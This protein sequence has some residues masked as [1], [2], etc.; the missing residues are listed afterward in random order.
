[1]DLYYRLNAFTLIIPPLRERK[2]DIPIIIKDMIKQ[3]DCI[4]KKFDDEVMKVFMRYNWNGN[5]RELKNCVEYMFCMG[6]D[7]LTI[8]DLPPNFRMK[9]EQSSNNN[10]YNSKTIDGFTKEET[11]ILLSV[12]KIVRERNAGRVLIHKILLDYGYS[13]SEYK[14]RTLMSYLNKNNYIIYGGGR[15]GANITE[16]GNLLVEEC[17]LAGRLKR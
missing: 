12:L 8:D 14:L 16:K 15:K 7:I 13:V 1:M 4:D 9:F 6:Q 10:I 2:E 5:V 17:D 11:D 3:M